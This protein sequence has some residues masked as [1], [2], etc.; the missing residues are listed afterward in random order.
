MQ[1]VFEDIFSCVSVQK[2]LW[3]CGNVRCSCQN[4]LFREKYLSFC[5][6]KAKRICL[7]KKTCYICGEVWKGLRKKELTN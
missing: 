3:A 7:T 5:I 1:S 2:W 6:K 4:R